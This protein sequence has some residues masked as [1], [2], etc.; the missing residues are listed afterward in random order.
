MKRLTMN[1]INAYLDGDLDDAGRAAVEMALETDAE[2]QQLLAR[3]R[4]QVNELHRLYDRVLDEPVPEDMLALLRS[5]RPAP[6]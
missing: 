6:N 4:Q 2:A 3:Y 1:D 5:N